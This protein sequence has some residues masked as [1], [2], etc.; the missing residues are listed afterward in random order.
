[1]NYLAHIYLSGSD[2]LHAL[3]NFIADDIKGFDWKKYPKKMQ[4]GILLHRAIDSYT[5]SHILFKK[6]VSLLFPI[7]RHYSRVIVDM[8][9]DHFLALHWM[10]FH[11]VPLDSFAENFYTALENHLHLLPK[12]YEKRL[13]HIREGNWFLKYASIEGLG[14]ILGQMEQRTRYSSKLSDSVAELKLYYSL[15]ESDFLVFFSLLCSYCKKHPNAGNYKE[16]PY[17]EV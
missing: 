6:H 16:L 7:Y 17:F 11:P 1:M 12:L 9:Y 2:T 10:Q 3:G 13:P 4:E 15:L 14:L 5:D 8:F